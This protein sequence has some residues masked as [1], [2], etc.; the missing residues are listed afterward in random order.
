MKEDELLLK[1]FV[2]TVG[3]DLFAVFGIVIVEKRESVKNKSWIQKNC[4]QQ[5]LRT[6]N[7]TGQEGQ[8]CQP[9]GYNSSAEED[10]VTDR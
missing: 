6:S 2:A 9:Q 5:E 8:R 3:D 4:A 10:E 1:F 7:L